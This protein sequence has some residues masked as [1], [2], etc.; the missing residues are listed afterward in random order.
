[1]K[2][3]VEKKYIITAVL[4]F[5]VIAASILFFLAVNNF[6]RILSA[7]S[8]LFSILSPVIFGF[9]FAYLLAPVLNFYEKT[10]L[11]KLNN[12]P[13]RKKLTRVLGMMM[14]YLSFL[15]IIVFFLWT[16]IPT[17]I[18]SIRGV[19]GNSNQ[20]IENITSF[21]NEFLKGSAAEGVVQDQLN[22][23]ADNII[24][25]MDMLPSVLN[26]AVSNL[27]TVVIEVANSIINI[28]IGVVISVYFLAGK[29]NFFA[30]TKK[31][32]FALFGK[33]VANRTIEITAHTHNVF[34]KFIFGRIIDSAIIGV[35]CYVGML[36]LRL[37]HPALIAFIVGIT[38][39]IP[40][41]GPFMGAI[42]SAILI[43]FDDWV[44]MIWFVI[45]ILILQQFDGNFLGPKIVGKSVGL[46]AFWVIFAI[47]I[48]GGLF[49]IPGIFMAVPI[50][51]II[52]GLFNAF[53]TRRL[54]SKGM[55]DKSSQYREITAEHEETTPESESESESGF[56]LWGK[57]K[58]LFWRKES[59]ETETRQTFE[60]DD[61][62]ARASEADINSN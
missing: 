7:I 51:V 35:I 12:N 19:I 22:N 6:G 13:E 28:L 37:P 59:P 42:P 10:V 41:F 20:Y 8:F 43:L 62:K 38:N 56:G 33:R 27:I 26:S 16:L 46:P 60:K 23:I 52:F 32:M 49:G 54:Q 21:V 61:L 25:S 45:F 30:Q 18:D 55:P 58:G 9:A 39:I 4:S 31:V 29:E 1:M 47:L 14:T 17:L 11:K 44:K 15:A 50:F 34:S 5:L 57:V 48:G 3:R 36:I 24:N 40:F 53:I 2:L